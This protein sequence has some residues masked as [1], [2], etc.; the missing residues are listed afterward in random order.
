VSI[1]NLGGAITYNTNKNYNMKKVIVVLFLIIVG[2][3][4][5]KQKIEDL[6]NKVKPS[7]ITYFSSKLKEYKID[8]IHIYGID[9]LTER[10]VF[11]YNCK[12][13]ENK[14]VANHEKMSQL[15][16]EYL[17]YSGLLD[18]SYNKY[19]ANKIILLKEEYKKLLKLN[20]ALFRLYQ[21]NDTRINTADNKKFLNYIALVNLKVSTTQMVQSNLDSLAI[22][23]TPDFKIYEREDYTQK[24][25]KKYNDTAQNKILLTN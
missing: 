21:I 16:K 12:V 1:T 3:K 23:F 7:L 2:C 17:D 8:S 19:A 22:F 25:I 24:E 11:A 5:E 6:K 18:I 4:S 13:L 20:D 15:N 14:I 10:K 9:T